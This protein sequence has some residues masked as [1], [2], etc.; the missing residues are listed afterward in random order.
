MIR[1]GCA[2]S[3]IGPI[4]PAKDTGNARAA[5]R[6]AA[7]P[8]A[9]TERDECGGEERGRRL[10]KP[11]GGHPSCG[12]EQD[13]VPRCFPSGRSRGRS[14][15]P[16]LRRSVR[17]DPLTRGTTW[18]DQRQVSWLPDRRSPVPSQ[19]CS[20]QWRTSGSLPGD[21]AR[22]RAGISPASL[23]TPRERGEPR[24]DCYVGH[25]MAG[26]SSRRNAREL[27][28]DRVLSPDRDAPADRPASRRRA[29]G[30]PGRA[31]RPPSRS[32]NSRS[33]SRPTARVRARPS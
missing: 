5:G 29:S 22:N 1:S 31:V 26:Q 2:E 14:G 11:T 16:P 28:A 3:V 9:R 24:V 6:T 15:R 18:C 19:S 7:A 10:P 32:S 25:I 8:L 17:T 27:L 30:R 20:L 13:D 33:R 4:A 21:S 23:F 12:R